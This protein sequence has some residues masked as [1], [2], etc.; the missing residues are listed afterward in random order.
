MKTLA[1]AYVA[2]APTLFEG[3]SPA[4]A[5]DAAMKNM[6]FWIN[7]REGAVSGTE[8]A[9]NAAFDEVAKTL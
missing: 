1:Q 6:R 9:W 7:E 4:E 5:K 3:K 2:Q 8:K